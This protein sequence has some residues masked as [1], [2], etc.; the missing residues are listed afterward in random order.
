MDQTM[1]LLFRL[2]FIHPDSEE[3]MKSFSGNYFLLGWIIVSL[4]SMQATG[5]Q[6]AAIPTPVDGQI[7]DVGTDRRAKD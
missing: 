3:I 6:M 7:T 5:T 2:F 1:I 4:T